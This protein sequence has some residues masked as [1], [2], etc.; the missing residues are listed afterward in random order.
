M[1]ELALELLGFVDD[2]VDELGSRRQVSGILNILRDG[3]SADRQLAVYRETKDLKAVVAAP[4]AGNAGR[5]G[6]SD[7]DGMRGERS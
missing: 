5:V 1:R 2:V 7:P 3:T 6:G 4:G